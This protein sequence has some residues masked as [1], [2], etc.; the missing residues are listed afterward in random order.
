M[1]AKKQRKKG[2]QCW[3]FW[4]NGA[5]LGGCDTA[6]SLGKQWSVWL[7]QGQ[8]K[9]VLMER[10]WGSEW[11]FWGKEWHKIMSTFQ[12]SFGRNSIKGFQHFQHS[13][14]WLQE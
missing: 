13:V 14:C 2:R 4:G 3:P 1:A 12:K 5:Y 9:G 11:N 7:C 10:M 8:E 6:T